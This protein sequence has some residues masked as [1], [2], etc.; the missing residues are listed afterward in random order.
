MSSSSRGRR[1]AAYSPVRDLSRALRRRPSRPRHAAVSFDASVAADLK[2]VGY[3]V[4]NLLDRLE[5]A[6]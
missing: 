1:A 2:A 4:K 6:R 5:P 3:S